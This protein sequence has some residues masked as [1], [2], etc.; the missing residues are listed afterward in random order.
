[1]EMRTKKIVIYTAIFGMK[2]VLPKQSFHPK[3]AHFVCFTDAR[4]RNSYGWEIRLEKPISLDPVRAAKIYKIL[5]HQYFPDYEYSVWID[6]NIVIRGD[7]WRLV[8]Q[9]LQNANFAAY[10]HMGGEDKRDCIYEE[11]RELLRAMDHGR[12]AGLNAD[13][14]RRQVRKYEAEGYPAHNGLITSMILLRKHNK[15]DVKNTMKDWW[16]EIEHGSRRDQL[17]FNYV[18]WKNNFTFN[19]IP[20]DSRKNAF[21]RQ[22]SH[23]KPLSATVRQLWKYARNICRE[24]IIA[25]NKKKE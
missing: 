1:M 11:A 8:E 10:N 18:A 7:V 3:N 12:Y 16:N 6:G 5:P 25:L 19:Y 20:G 2:D 9:Y 24:F 23:V 4:P 21:F 14:I 15:E 22:K 13:Q 17:S